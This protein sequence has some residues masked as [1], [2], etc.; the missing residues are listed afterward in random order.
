MKKLL[1]ITMSMFT[2][3][4]CNV[5]ANKNQ[6]VQSSTSCTENDDITTLKN[7]VTKNKKNITSEN[8]LEKINN[9]ELNNGVYHLKYEKH[10]YTIVSIRGYDYSAVS[11]VCSDCEKQSVKESKE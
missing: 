5:G 10:N 1:M 6:D 2:L 8:Y 11:I 9:I 3:M 4:S 7:S